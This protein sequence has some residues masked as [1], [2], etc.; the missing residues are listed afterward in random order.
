MSEA[1]VSVTIEWFGCTTFR[2]RAGDLTIFFDTYLDKAPGVSPAALRAADVDRADFLFIS[3]A[4]FDHVL[5]ADTIA[6][7]TGATVVGNYETARLMRANGIPDDQI[8]ATAGGDTVDCGHGVTV[9]AL[10][11]Q[12]SSLY[13]AGSLDSGEECLG[14][15]GMSAAERQTRTQGIFALLASAPDE[16][17]DFFERAGKSTSTYDGG[18]LAYLLESPA[19]SVLITASAGYWRGIFEPLRPDVAILGAS[20]RPVVDGEPYQGSLADFLAE[21]AA[22]LGHPQ[23]ILCHY[24]PLLPPLVG[25]TDITAAESRLTSMPGQAYRRLD[26]ATPTVLLRSDHDGAA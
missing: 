11:S 12:H 19:G 20:G 1:A 5:G 9:R 25:A 16:Y 24:D 22:L 17:R 6:A 15:L 14:D 18:Q 4:H 8:I 10:P 7:A 21:E 2:V 26:Y 3:H 23:V 13:A